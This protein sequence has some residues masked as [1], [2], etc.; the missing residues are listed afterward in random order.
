MPPG[1]LSRYLF[2]HGLTDAAGRL[3]LSDRVPYRYRVL[4]DNRFHVVNEGDTLFSLAHIYFS[5]LP[6]PSGLYWVIADFQP[7][8]IVD[9]TRKLSIGTQLVIPST[10]TLIEEIFNEARRDEFE[11]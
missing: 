11:G 3:F 7:D 4:Q 8:P 1:D 9:A 6:R 5:R 10:R 2:C